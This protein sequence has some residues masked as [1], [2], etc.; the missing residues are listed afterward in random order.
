MRLQ[1]RNPALASDI[2]GDPVEQRWLQ[3]IGL[4]ALAEV[5]VADARSAFGVTHG[6]QLTAYVTRPFACGAD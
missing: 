1:A 5:P 6:N 2:R 3:A 4:L